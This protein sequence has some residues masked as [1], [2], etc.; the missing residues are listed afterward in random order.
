MALTATGPA[1]LV[2]SIAA[3]APTAMLDEHLEVTQDEE[4]RDSSESPIN[5]RAD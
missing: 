1:R 4:E 2:L 3:Q 5:E